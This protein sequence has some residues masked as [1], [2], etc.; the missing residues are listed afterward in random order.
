[1][2]KVDRALRFH[3]LPPL[4]GGAA[5]LST[6]P[7][8]AADG[9]V[10]VA[11]VGTGFLIA[12]LLAAAGYLLYRSRQPDPTTEVP[13]AG[14]A[15][16]MALGRQGFV[17]FG[18]GDQARVANIGPLLGL[19]TDEDL[20]PRVALDNLVATDDSSLAA[21]IDALREG[22]ES[23]I[24]DATL[25]GENDEQDRRFRLQGIRIPMAEDRDADV[26]WVREVTDEVDRVESLETELEQR[27]AVLDVFPIPIWMRS[28][29]LSLIYC[30]DYY[31]DAV[32]AESAAQAIGESREIAGT[33]ISETGKSLAR[34]AR[35]MGTALSQRHHVV[36]NGARRLLEITELPL[37]GT[38]LL[39]GFALDRTDTEEA[40]SALKRHV[41]AHAEVLENLATAVAIY[42][43][44]RR[45]RF[46]NT[47]FLSLWQLDGEFLYGQPTLGEV[48]EALRESRRLPEYADFPAWKREQ[49]RQF[50]TV[51]DSVEGVLHLP[52]GRTLRSLTS[53]HPL[54]GLMFLYEDV[55][56]R[57]ALERSHNTLIAV[58]RETLD[59]LHEGVAV[60]GSDGLVK[61]FNPEFAHLWNLPPDF[62]DEGPHVRDLVTR[63]RPLLEVANWER[64]SDRV[65]AHVMDRNVYNGRIERIDGTVIEYSFVPLPDGGKLLS[66]TN[67]TDSYRV[68][69][70]LREQ[71]ETLATTDRLKTEFLTNVSYELRT[72]LNTI[73]GFTEILANGYYGTF[74]EKQ[75]EYVDGILESAKSLLALVDNILDLAMI[76]AGRLSLHH[77]PVDLDSM[78][79]EIAELG[80]QWAR[81]GDHQ[82]RLDLDPDTGSIRAD[83]RRLKQAM[84][85]LVSN[86]LAFT[87][88]G[89]K[90]TIFGR[91]DGEEVEIG[92]VDT[93]IGIDD[94]SRT[95]IFDKFE[96]GAGPDGRPQGAG[97]G[98]ALV[99]QIVELHGG[100]VDL[101]SSPGTGTTVSCHLPD[102]PRASSGIE[103]P[104]A[105]T[106]T[107]AT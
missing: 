26:V 7:A 37:P 24:L 35:D 90:I 42:G 33:A 1:M 105:E 17:L 74:N 25:S 60:V 68:Q 45:L 79:Q 11:G 65:V 66:Y 31:V 69:R 43:P 78:L 8:L 12:V 30:N 9:G 87:P 52:D 10:T 16:M 4:I 96:R 93:G 104:A 28:R 19:G 83:S 22:G 99:K 20:D 100:V 34:E 38:P 67:R 21:S 13:A 61:L 103:G 102:A 81:A 88:A 86:A 39:I 89:G 40:E 50:T 47:A 75:S 15:A 53:A 23:F 36:V 48:L 46:F 41:G 6:R 18:S 14:M 2:L 56:D 91:R 62:L 59:N 3:L 63:S 77:G 98:L 5:A 76:E 107:D 72:P 85:N 73:I 106:M 71:A 80:R 94:E 44:D 27:S 32:E 95:R 84:M 57:L 54:G 101:T 29:D 82:I 70:A 51:I 55:T 97:L 92:V 64:F 58:Q 49:E